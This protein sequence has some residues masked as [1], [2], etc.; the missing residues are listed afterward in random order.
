MR[1]KI[2]LTLLV[3]ILLIG[4]PYYWLLLDN[5]PGKAAPKPV[6]I[7]QLRELASSVPGQAPAA[8]ELEL[9]AQRLV[10]RTL[11]AAGNGIKR[12]VIGVMAWRLSVPGGK[13]V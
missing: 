4:L 8:L 2:N 1:R 9:V 10:P 5:R 12:A 7:G 13:P 11:F 6:T 3:L